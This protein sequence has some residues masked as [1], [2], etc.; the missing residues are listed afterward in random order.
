MSASM[1]EADRLSPIDSM[2]R[3]QNLLVPR[4]SKLGT[5]I[6][7]PPEVAVVF[8]DSLTPEDLDD[9]HA[10]LI[11]FGQGVIKGGEDMAR[12]QVVETAQRIIGE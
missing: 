12:I 5:G 10:R 8:L 9:H 4:D 2:V 3:S 1:Y 11:R 6:Y 7:M